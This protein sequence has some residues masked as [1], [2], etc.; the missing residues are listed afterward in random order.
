M[1]SE[2]KIENALHTLL[3]NLYLSFKLC[4]ISSDFL[5]NAMSVSIKDWPISCVKR[6]TNK[7]NVNAS[8][9]TMNA[10][11]INA[12]MINHFISSI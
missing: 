3:Y 9:I 7:K 10:V 6:K 1:Q 4:R 5:N 11:T 12:I 8:T 2:R